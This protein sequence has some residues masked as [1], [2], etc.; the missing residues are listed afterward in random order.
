VPEHGGEAAIEAMA[1]GDPAL[2]MRDL[3]ERSEMTVLLAGALPQ[4]AEQSVEALLLALPARVTEPLPMTVQPMR[5]EL[6]LAR[7]RARMQ[8]AKVV[9][10]LRTKI[11]E[12]PRAQAALQAAMSLWGGGPHSRL[13]TEVREKRSLCY[14]ASAGG[15]SDKGIVLMQSGCDASAVDAVG[16]ESMAQLREIAEGKFS[17]AELATAVA[18]CQGPL[19]SIDDSPAARLSFT[20]DQFLRGFDE[21]PDQRIASLGALSRDEVAAVAASTWL[22][23]DYALLP[24]GAP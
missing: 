16:R 11:P 22:D 1:P 21:T 14:Y 12:S 24:E 20:A 9:L 18:A 4:G 17:D 7:D 6:R 19:R 15:D 23:V 3:L 13:F 5:R 2:A 8:Q 10:V